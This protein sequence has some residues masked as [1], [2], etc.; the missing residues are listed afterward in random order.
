MVKAKVYSLCQVPPSMHLG[1]ADVTI[2]AANLVVGQHGWELRAGLF[3]EPLNEAQQ[4]RLF[5]MDNYTSSASRPGGY[6]AT[7]IF[8]A[9]D[10]TNYTTCFGVDLLPLVQAIHCDIDGKRS[11][12]KFYGGEGI[13]DGQSAVLCRGSGDL[14][15]DAAAG[16]RLTIA[17]KDRVILNMALP[18]CAS[19]RER[20][21]VSA[22]SQPLYDARSMEREH[23]TLLHDWLVYHRSIGVDR[24]SVYDTDGSMSATVQRY[25][26]IEYW[27]DWSVT[28]SRSERGFR[29]LSTNFPLC[30]QIFAY[31]HCLISSFGLSDWVL[32][33]HA[34]DEYINVHRAYE[35][36]LDN[37]V[38]RIFNFIMTEG[39]LSRSRLSE[40]HIPMYSFQASWPK[41]GR[42]SVI[43]SSLLR[44]AEPDSFRGMPALNPEVCLNV[45]GHRCALGL[46]PD[47]TLVRHAGRRLMP[48]GLMRVNHYTEMLARD[49]GRCSRIGA[50]SCNVA[51][52][53][54]V[55]VPVWFRAL[56]AHRRR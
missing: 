41:L 44:A 27:R 56:E 37:L 32:L 6:D 47:G 43:A 53:S 33:L 50:V 49:V 1:I 19:K 25:D 13:D 14:L 9:D 52:G 5:G 39:N 17:L 24:F 34:P 18:L 40:I 2:F 16:A 23:P 45:D 20:V 35:Q 4:G 22:C 26:F 10:L 8:G 31:A 54:L 11:L 12:A 42:G 48:P 55:W 3:A 28:I 38:P 51:D 29:N 30:T 15:A 7:E 36:R 46:M 21:P